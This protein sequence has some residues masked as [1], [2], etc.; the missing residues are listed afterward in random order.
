[1][2]RS[3]KIKCKDRTKPIDQSA[4]FQVPDNGAGRNASINRFKTHGATIFLFANKA[5]KIKN[6]GSYDDADLSSVNT[7]RALL[8]GHPP[9]CLRPAKST[10]TIQER[11]YDTIRRQADRILGQGHAVVLDAAHGNP[12]AFNSAA[13]VANGCRSVEIYLKTTTQ[14]RFTRVESHGG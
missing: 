12:D 6:A 2:E 7:W 5:V 10:R 8:H 14:P 9:D 11:T 3:E 13:T 1:M 4:A